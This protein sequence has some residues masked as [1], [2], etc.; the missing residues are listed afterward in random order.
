MFR[1]KLIV[2]YKTKIRKIAREMFLQEY[3]N[4]KMSLMK[5]DTLLD[6]FYI[7]N[8]N[9]SCLQCHGYL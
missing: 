3:L 4:N 2:D 9:K 6:H 5:Y 8:E 7:L 1:L